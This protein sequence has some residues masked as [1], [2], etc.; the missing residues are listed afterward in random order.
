MG[1]YFETARPMTFSPAGIA[2]ARRNV[3]QRIERFQRGLEGAG[4]PPNR[5]DLYYLREAFQKLEAG[6]YP[7]AE[8]AAGVRDRRMTQPILKRRQAWRRYD[9]GRLSDVA[10]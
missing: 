6:P 5:R 7:E 2:T 4:R 8:D 3:A 1:L 9:G 10:Q